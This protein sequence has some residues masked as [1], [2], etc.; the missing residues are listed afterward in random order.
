MTSLSLPRPRRIR[1]LA[2]LV[3]SVALVAASQVATLLQARPAVPGGPTGAGTANGPAAVAPIAP[4]DAP[5]QGPLQYAPGSVAQID[6]SI[7]AWT[8]NLAANDKDF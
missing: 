4:V 1:P 2:I 6:H 5:G 3:A 7:A 8:A